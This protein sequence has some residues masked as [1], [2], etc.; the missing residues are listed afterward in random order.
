MKIHPTLDYFYELSVNNNRIPILGEKVVPPFE[1]AL[2]FKNLFY[3]KNN[4]F[5]YE[6]INGSSITS[7]Y[8][9][10]GTPNNNYVRIERDSSSFKLN[11][12][13]G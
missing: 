1:L 11:K 13:S 10:M 9:F 2:L 3:G 5:L 6:S 12:E 7:Q 8:S 4:T